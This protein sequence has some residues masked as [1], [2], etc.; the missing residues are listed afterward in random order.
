MN[1]LLE[2]LK[3][4]ITKVEADAIV[5]AANNSLLGGGGVDGAIHKAGGPA[6]L[7]EC[8]QIRNRQAGCKTGDAVITTAGNLPAKKVIHTVGPV[9]MGGGHNEAALL[10]SC[11]TKSLTLAME[12]NLRTV[13]FPNISTG[14]YRYPKQEAAI[15]A[16]RTVRQF[17][18]QH[19]SAIEKITFV[20]FDDESYF[21]Y[22]QLM[23]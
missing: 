6:I 11:Y 21:I 4:D 18:E 23:K 17:I 10:S 2:V 16:V 15:I 22:N 8:I 7:E 20:C 5:N 12:N 9:Y 14:I 1:T 13:A 3:G 19:P